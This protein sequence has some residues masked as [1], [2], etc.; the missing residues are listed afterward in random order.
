MNPYYKAWLSITGGGELYE[1]MIW[2]FH[3]H[4][5]YQKSITFPL[6]IMNALENGLNRNVSFWS[7]YDLYTAYGVC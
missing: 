1:Y 2:I 7:P 6:G 4:R 3:M 5:E